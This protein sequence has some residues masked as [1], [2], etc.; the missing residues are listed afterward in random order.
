MAYEPLESH[1]EYLKAVEQY[2]DYEA[3]TYRSMTLEEKMNFFD[4]IHTNHIPLF[5]EDGDDMDTSDDYYAIRDEFLEHPEQ[6]T[7]DHIL[8]FIKMLD[9]NCYQP[10]FM[11]TIM[12]IIHNIVCYY[13]LGGVTYLLSHLHEVPSRG[14]E[15]GLFHNVRYLIKN[16]A[17][18]PLVME[19]LTQ[20][21]P[22]DREFVLQILEGTNMPAILGINS[23]TRKFPLL[24]ECGD[25]IEMKRKDELT[26][27]ISRLS[28]E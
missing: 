6:F 2:Q 23:E 24:S 20:I 12:N 15:L 17:V 11:D 8:E 28:N 3:G 5:D 25:E 16:D 4:G 18:Y 10:S 9:D 14:Y 27:I 19:A 26:D 21:S 1:D 13:Q 22:D 7:L